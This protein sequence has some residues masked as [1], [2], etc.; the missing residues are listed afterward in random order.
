MKKGSQITTGYKGEMVFCDKCLI[1]V[2]GFAWRLA[3]EKDS[4]GD[5]YDLCCVHYNENED[6]HSRN[7]FYCN[8]P[9]GYIPSGE[10][11]SVHVRSR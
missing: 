9:T 2:M 4:T 11:E 5:L 8:I 3:K 6:P 7:H 1:P 10:S